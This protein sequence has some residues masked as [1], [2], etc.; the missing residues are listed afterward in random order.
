M[1]KWNDSKIQSTYGIIELTPLYCIYF[2][3]SDGV[4]SHINWAV[5]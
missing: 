1:D 3:T 4:T 5:H 2:H